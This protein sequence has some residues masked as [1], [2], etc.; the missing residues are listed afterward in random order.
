[1]EV[2]ILEDTSSASIV[3]ALIKYMFYHGAKN[4]F[5]SDIGSNCLPLATKYATFPDKEIK[6]LSPMWQKLLSK[7]IETLTQDGGYL[8]I[9]FSTERHQALG[10]IEKMVDKFKNN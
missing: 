8:W 4:I 2:E 9:L 10:R 3:S 6:S 5:L 1:M 7:D